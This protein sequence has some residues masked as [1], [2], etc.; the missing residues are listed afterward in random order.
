MTTTKKAATAGGIAL[1]GATG[2]LIVSQLAEPALP[3]E[4]PPPPPPEY[5]MLEWEQTNGWRSFEVLGTTNFV[6]WYRIAFT[7]KLSIR[8]TN[9]FPHE[10]F[11]VRAVDYSNQPQ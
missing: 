5:F 3:E 10:F 2:A 9:R 6:D 7:E 1:I 11:M 8:V 4:P